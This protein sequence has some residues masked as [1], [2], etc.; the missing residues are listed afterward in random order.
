MTKAEYITAVTLEWLATL[1]CTKISFTA[2]GYV[3]F[4]RL[5]L[6]YTIALPSDGFE[7]WDAE[8]HESMYAEWERWTQDVV[9]PELRK[10]SAVPFA[11]YLYQVGEGRALYYRILRDG[12][13]LV[14]G[15]PRVA[16]TGI[17]LYALELLPDTIKVLISTTKNAMQGINT[18]KKQ[19]NKIEGWHGFLLLAQ[20]SGWCSRHQ[21]RLTTPHRIKK[22]PMEEWGT[23]GVVVVDE[24]HK[25]YSNVEIAD[26]EMYTDMRCVVG[27][28]PVVLVT[29]TPH[30][31]SYNQLF[32]QFNLSAYSPFAKDGLTS[33]KQYFDQWGIP[34]M[35]LVGNGIARPVYTECHRDEVEAIASPYIMTLSRADV[36]YREELEPTDKRVYIELTGTTALLHA[37]MLTKEQVVINTEIDGTSQPVHLIPLSS[38]HARQVA[39]QIEGG[40]AKYVDEFSVR[41]AETGLKIRGVK[42]PEYNWQLTALPDKVQWILDNGYDR[43]DVVVMYHYVNE[44]K[45]L[46]KLLKNA[47]VLQG[48]TNAEGVDLWEYDT[49]IVYSMDWSVATYIQRRDRQVHTTKRT[50]PIEVLYLLVKGGTSEEVYDTVVDGGEDLTFSYYNDRMPTAVLGVA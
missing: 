46:R 2:D 9:L 41:D 20:A 43:A 4:T 19:G 39:H 26:T 31:Q 30:A 16:K 47:R 42:A 18:S 37:D 27:R 50:V 25:I 49:V 23:F 40:T 14:M 1:S 35:V 10:H 6:Q 38:G 24:S 5:A 29:A 36:G 13:A 48:K 17:V 15:Q 45:M 3:K 34:K 12:L 28:S 8:W 33:F 7:D 44:G 32:R 21:Y 22:I 11:W